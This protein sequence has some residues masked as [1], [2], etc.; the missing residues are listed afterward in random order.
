[1]KRLS[2]L[3]RWARFALPTLALI[4]ALTAGAFLLNNS[5]ASTRSV[6]IANHALRYV[7]GYGSAECP[8][9]H[10]SDCNWCRGFVNYAVLYITGRMPYASLGN[11]Q[12]SFARTGAHEVSVNTASKG[13]I[14][15]MGYYNWS[16]P[17][18]TAIILKAVDRGKRIFQVVDAN[19]I[20]HGRN[21][22]HVQIH[23]Y[24]V[25]FGA[26]FWNY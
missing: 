18:H 15:Q 26:R 10:K 24:Q 12:V 23:N 16:Y 20:Y 19:W 9:G 14:V 3:P 5:M 8:S 21:D 22:G 13:T 11:Y 4:V 17:L 2:R 7:G 6:A 25:P 1:M